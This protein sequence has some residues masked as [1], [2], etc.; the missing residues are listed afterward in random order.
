MGM[1]AWL[2]GLDVLELGLLSIL[3]CLWRTVFFLEFCFEFL[4]SS[5]IKEA[6]A[7]SVQHYI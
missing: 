2:Q 6:E 1:W 3:N 5:V 7:F 4:Y